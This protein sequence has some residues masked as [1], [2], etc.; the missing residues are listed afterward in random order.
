MHLHMSVSK[1]LTQAS[2]VLQ[3]YQNFTE[4]T[5]NMIYII[6]CGIGLKCPRKIQLNT[7]WRGDSYGPGMRVIALA[8]TVNTS[9]HTFSRKNGAKSFREVAFES[10]CLDNFTRYLL[11]FWL[12]IEVNISWNSLKPNTLRS[13]VLRHHFYLPKAIH[14]LILFYKQRIM[15]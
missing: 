12:P 9:K 2:M 3:N 13:K 11:N 6:A 10:L 15:Y 8:T 5:S 4:M 1:I 7:Q 14:T